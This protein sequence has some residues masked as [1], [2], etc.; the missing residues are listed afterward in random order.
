M[1]A[2]RERVI[3]GKHAV[4][5]ALEAGQPIRRI[6]VAAQSSAGRDPR[7]EKALR[8]TK[9]KVSESPREALDRLAEGGRH[10]GIIA[11]LSGDFGY[12]KLADLL[13][14]A[15]KAEKNPILVACDQITDPHNLGAIIRSAEAFGARGVI[16]PE[17][18]SASVTPV[19]EKSSA[20]ATA[21][22]PVAQV[23]NLSDSF[24]RAKEAGYWIVGADAGDGDPLFK[25][26]FARP[27]ILVIGAEG[28]GMR[29]RVRGTC[30]ALVNIPTSGKVASLNASVAAGVLLYE[31]IRQR[32][33]A[34]R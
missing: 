12:L 13:E 1:P 10:Q 18:R 6:H 4:L 11:V 8:R 7:L 21:H 15:L 20:G 34:G 16:V 19:V 32:M 28:K 26:D 25:F 33:G 2:T 3:Y 23:V 9:V 31:V 17:R 24:E 30:D 5:E 14:R 27:L 29:T 22:L